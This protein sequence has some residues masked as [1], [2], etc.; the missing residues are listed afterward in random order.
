VCAT[1][2]EDV[3]GEILAYL[4]EHPHAMDTLSGIAEWWIE[5]HR[6]RVDV[7][8]LSGVIRRLVERG[9]LQK[10]GDDDDPLYR[11]TPGRIDSAP[12]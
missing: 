8:A 9:A 6:I 3:E 5:R 1:P 11:L 4:A 7:E 12:N 2:A 10:L